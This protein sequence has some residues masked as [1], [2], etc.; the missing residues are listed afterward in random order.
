MTRPRAKRAAKCGRHRQSRRD[1]R[2]KRVERRLGGDAR[3]AFVF[4]ASRVARRQSPRGERAGNR[5]AP[6][7]PSRASV[8]APIGGY[9]PSRVSDDAS[10]RGEDDAADANV[11]VRRERGERRRRRAGSGR[12]TPPCAELGAETNTTVATDHA[13][14]LLVVAVVVAMVVAMVVAVVVAV[15][16]AMVVA[17]ATEALGVGE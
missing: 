12:E 4:D 10:E 14:R 11:A 8:R 5:A 3:V 17:V 6:R 15:L 9:D 13:T 16:V 1:A 7:G 2:A